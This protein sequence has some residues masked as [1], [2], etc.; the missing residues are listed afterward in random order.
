[1]YYT[2]FFFVFIRAIIYVNLFS[3]KKWILVDIQMIIST[4]LFYQDIFWQHLWSYK[5]KKEAMDLWFCF[6]KHVLIN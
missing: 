1:M 6:K 3:T 2:D 4:R 5:R